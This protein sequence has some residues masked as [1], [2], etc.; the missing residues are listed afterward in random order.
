MSRTPPG[1][2]IHPGPP[3]WRSSTTNHAA[4]VAA[5]SRSRRRKRG[6][7]GLH[8]KS[9]L[10]T[11]RATRRVGPVRNAIS[12]RE[13]AVKPRSAASVAFRELGTA[14]GGAKWLSLPHGPPQRVRRTSSPLALP[15]LANLSHAFAMPWLCPAAGDVARGGIMRMAAGI[16]VGLLPLSPALGDEDWS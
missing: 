3:R 15:P 6:G 14:A 1:L 16:I 2:I 4:S 10:R 12:T 9:A 8:R 5:D 13:C 7:L 11:P